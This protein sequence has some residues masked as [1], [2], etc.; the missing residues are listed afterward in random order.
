MR[1]TPQTHT[2]KKSTPINHKLLL[3]LPSSMDRCE[4]RKFLSS[5]VDK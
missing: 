1:N 3:P 4:K 5:F 2:L